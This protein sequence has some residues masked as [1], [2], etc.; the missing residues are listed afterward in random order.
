MRVFRQNPSA[1]NDKPRIR[2][3]CL[4][5]SS[6]KSP[7]SMSLRLG[8]AAA[9]TLVATLPGR[10]AEK[11]HSVRLS[12]WRLFSALE[13][14]AL[15]EPSVEREGSTA[16]GSGLEPLGALDPMEPAS[17][18]NQWR[19]A[20]DLETQADA[21]FAQWQV[22]EDRLIA[23]PFSSATPAATRKAARHAVAVHT[24]PSGQA[25]FYAIEES[26]L[27]RDSEK[28][29]TVEVR[30]FV[31]RRD[32][33]PDRQPAPAVYTC[34]PAG[35][36]F[37]FD[38]FLGYLRAGDRICVSVG[39]D[40]S[41]SGD[42]TEVQGKA[43]RRQAIPV[44]VLS[45]DAAGTDAVAAPGGWSFATGVA[46]ATAA[47]RRAGWRHQDTA[48]GRR[49]FS[50]GPLRLDL[51]SATEPVSTGGLIAFRV[52]H[53][54]YYALHDAWAR[55]TAPTDDV[56][57]IRGGIYIGREAAPRYE[58]ALR[59]GR[60]RV[61]LST[62]LGYIAK[63]DAIYICLAPTPGDERP[64]SVEFDATVVEWAPRRPPLRVR[65]G[66]DGYLNVYEPDAPR[67]AVDI[68]ADRWIRVPN[69]DGDS[70][71]AIRE[72]LKQ[73]QR[74]HTGSHD[75]AGI[76][77]EDGETYLVASEQV[78]GNVFDIRDS[79]R[80]I[81]D[82]NGAT[83]LIASP[84]LERQEVTLFK[85]TN[86]RSI[87]VA[88]LTTEDREVAFTT[89]MILDVSPMQEGRQTV[90]FRVDPESPHPIE[91]IRPPGHASGYAYDPDIP[92]RLGLGTWSHYP[93]AGG[94]EPTL[95]ATERPGVF[96]H[97]VLRTKNSIKPGQR[98]LV[99]NKRGGVRY[100]VTDSRS[101]DITMWRI[102]ARA[103]GG[104]LLRFWQ[105]SGVNL[106]ECDFQPVD[107]EW[108]GSTS[109][110]IHGRG[111]EGVWVED[112]I[113]RGVCED[114]MNTYAIDLVVF[115]DDHPDDRVIALRRHLRKGGKFPIPGADQVGPGDKLVFFNP[116]SGKSLGHAMVRSRLPGGRFRLSNAIEGIDTWEKGDGKRA[117]MVYNPAVAARFYVR[118]SRMMDSMRFG[119]FIKA[120]HSVM[121]NTHFEGL[122]A[123]AIF[124][125][126]QPDWPEGPPPTHL[127]I[128]GNT[129]NQ[130]TISYM[131]RHRDYIS[132]DP[133]DISIFTQQLRAAT[134]PHSYEARVTRGQYANSHMKIMG[135]TFRDWRGMGIAV[136]NSRNV[137]IRDNLFLPP[138]DDAVMRRTLASDPALR[139]D[140]NGQYAGIF[141]DSVN[142]AQ[143]ADNL[144][145]GLPG[146]DRPLAEGS[147]VANL[148]V[149]GN[150]RQAWKLPAVSVS[151]PFSEW[152]GDV[153]HE[154]EKTGSVR[155]RVVLK[156]AA[157]VP[158]RF[159]AGLR[160]SGAG[161]RAVLRP[162]K[163]VDM[164]SATSRTLALW[165][166]P[167]HVSGPVQVVFDHGRNDGNRGITITIEDG[168][169]AGRAWARDTDCRLDLGPAVPGVWQHITLVHDGERQTFAG[170]VNGLRTALREHEVPRLSGVFASGCSFGAPMMPKRVQ[171]TQ[172]RPQPAAFKGILDEFRLLH[173]VATPAEIALLAEMRPPATE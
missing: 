116:Q 163:D 59:T 167:E 89:G 164:R 100:L 20:A 25:G 31:R 88:D 111:R 58:F 118:D 86:S 15:G 96:T 153:S 77:L 160:F 50:E 121:F 159:G 80:V 139:G 11:A 173:R 69:R 165:I 110:G 18:R 46:L 137:H 125:A 157:H 140:E 156:G 145:V 135:N 104:G 62:D 9:I 161:S 126:N 87:L 34:L 136:R 150:T 27:R 56:D 129:F 23:L 113:L 141:L 37:D 33:P 115:P 105:T 1:G 22:R 149:A 28:P 90:T 8:C 120:Q 42:R 124:A 5:S 92:G 109:D 4:A 72:A 146:N 143:L 63:G 13:Q 95:R 2:R 29:G 151:L 78:G 142:G 112:T 49:E 60:D 122:A 162:S 102:R 53:S 40:G 41:S 66:V 148:K 97:R 133:A 16:P 44:S 84:E 47:E 64:V 101:G 134:D 52:P 32:I 73:A 35:E 70:T 26:F 108:I 130:N 128:Q 3:H 93:D 24:V 169:F 98:W 36:V 48:A 85:T 17:S 152:F 67:V 61:P 10:A 65:R 7:L 91:D 51:S 158:G 132:V 94:K 155:D 170:Y 144:F 119:I 30:V 21:P 45:E 154:P 99:K 68:P 103:A 19:S 38:T 123:A 74:A 71:D 107:R 43:V 79:E 131:S 147:Q 39:P 57:A 83:L 14:P 106:L 166:N 55:R 172:E 82:G 76:R 75:Y 114:I 12:R 117:T 81:L 127:W 6:S 138:V 171:G 54:G 168:R